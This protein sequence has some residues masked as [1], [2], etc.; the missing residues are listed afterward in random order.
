[1][2]LTYELIKPLIK[3]EEL[4]YGNQIHLEFC[5]KNQEIPIQTVAV[6]MANEDEITKNAT[7]QV[8]KGAVKNTILNQ[9]L[10]FLGISGIAGNFLKSQ[11]NEIINKKDNSI[12][13][14]KITTDKKQKAIV[15][16]FKS[17]MAMYRYNEQNLEWEFIT[18]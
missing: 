13:S 12:I 8:I 5:A 10:N 11:T 6:I 4:L 18:N 17:I 14:G 9:I 16:A 7:K 3:K 1:M 15:D 2:E